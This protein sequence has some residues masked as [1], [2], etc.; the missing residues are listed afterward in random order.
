ML[1]YFSAFGCISLD[2]GSAAQKVAL[3]SL[4]AT[5]VESLPISGVVD[6]NVSVPISTM[7]VAMLAF[8]YGSPR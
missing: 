4:V 2:W 3:V 7:I 5:V 8:G 1:C 6:D